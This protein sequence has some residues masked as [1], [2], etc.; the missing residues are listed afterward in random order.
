[1]LLLS[2]RP[3]TRLNLSLMF[4]E[5]F[6]VFT[7]GGSCFF[8]NLAI[9]DPTAGAKLWPLLVRTVVRKDFCR[10]AGSELA[11]ITDAEFASL[12]RWSSRSRRNWSRASLTAASWL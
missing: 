2:L 6:L 4:Q 9:S 12:R 3:K 7:T 8:V 10:D 1:M 5:D 11:S